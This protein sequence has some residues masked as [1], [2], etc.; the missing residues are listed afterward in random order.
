MSLS[1]YQL[2]PLIKIVCS[3]LIP[4]LQDMLQQLALEVLPAYAANLTGL[5]DVK[6]A[7][8]QETEGMLHE[9]FPA[10]LCDNLDFEI[11]AAPIS[12]GSGHEPFHPALLIKLL[13]VLLSSL[14]VKIVAKGLQHPVFKETV[15][16]LLVNPPQ[17]HVVLE[18]FEY[19][20]FERFVMQTNTTL[21]KV[22]QMPRVLTLPLL[23]LLSAVLYR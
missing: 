4:I 3:D 23:L 7:F 16:S 5:L 15:R 18:I 22:E 9:G 17:R 11:L 19:L 13:N 6:C 21:L 12:E 10:E 2:L 14:L 8:E 20:P 1:L